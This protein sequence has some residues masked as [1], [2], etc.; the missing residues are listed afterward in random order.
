MQ[1]VSVHLLPARPRL[2]RV[3]QRGK[4]RLARGR[5]DVR[6]REARAPARLRDREVLRERERVPVPDVRL[7]LRE[8]RVPVVRCAR[9]REEAEPREPRDDVQVCDRELVAWTYGEKARRE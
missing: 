7:D 8:R 5:L 6:R 9:P 2:H 4:A 1:P 3:P